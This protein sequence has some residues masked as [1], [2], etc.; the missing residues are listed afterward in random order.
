MCLGLSLA[1]DTPAPGDFLFPLAVFSVANISDL[2]LESFPEG[3]QDTCTKQ[4]AKVTKRK[5]E[6]DTSRPCR[7]LSFE[8][9]EAQCTK[10]AGML[11]YYY[12]LFPLD[13][14]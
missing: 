2:V 7:K 10:V 5:C 8:L 6:A 12:F 3:I 9:C 11:L 13:S 14:P 1:A 4:M